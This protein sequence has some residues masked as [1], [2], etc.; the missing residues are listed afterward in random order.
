MQTAARREA[1]PGELAR[2]EALGD[3]KEPECRVGICDGSGYVMVKPDASKPGYGVPCKCVPL[4]FRAALAGI[5]E[6]YRHSAFENFEPMDGKTYALTEALAWDG[7]RPVVLAGPVGTGKT[8]LM[9]AMGLREME[10]GR[11]V[12]F[13]DV[14]D[15]LDEIKARFG[16]DQVQSYYEMIANSHTLLLDD[17]GAEQDTEWADAQLRALI[18]HRYSRQLPTIITTNLGYS[19][20]K[21]RLGEAVASRMSEWRWI[22]VGGIDVRPTLAAR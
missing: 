13:V 9:A 21:Q 14:R 1:T 15:F 19:E 6:R 12:K 17:L 10:R 20:I 7:K 16:T 4:S 5:P 3:A 11:P 2:A 22:A 8:H 18:N